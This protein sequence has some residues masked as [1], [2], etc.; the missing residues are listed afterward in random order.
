MLLL[1]A[2]TVSAQ[3]VHIELKNGEKYDYDSKDIKTMTIDNKKPKTYVVDGQIAGHD[4]VTIGGKK[5]ATMN[6][7]ATSVASSDVVETPSYIKDFT[8]NSTDNK[9]YSCFG[10][11]FKW[12]ETSATDGSLDYPT[13]NDCDNPTLCKEHDA[14]AVNWGST[15]RI[16]TRADFL[17]LSNACAGKTTRFA[18]TPLTAEVK[19]G[20][21][22][23]LSDTQEYEYDYTGVAGVLFV[24]KEDP[25]KRVFFPATGS[26]SNYDTL[27]RAGWNGQYW[28]SSFNLDNTKEAYDLDFVSDDILLGT[29]YTFRS[30]G[31]TVRPVS[32]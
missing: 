30:Y 6:I 25:S 24:D 29:G 12:G 32:D 19:E 21:I 7:G 1:V 14:A 31:F 2:T 13:L 15:W 16:P 23:W 17:A 18:P 10:T 8:Y 28:T 5:W 4:Y 3:Y 11:Y 9:V 26:I 20:G 22:Y 27:N